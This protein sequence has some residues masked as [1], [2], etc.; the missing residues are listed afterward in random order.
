MLLL[1]LIQDPALLDAIKD[2]EPAALRKIVEE[3]YAPPQA[4]VDET[5]ASIAA[6]GADDF[7]T[8][9]KASASLAK[10]A[11]LVG[12]ILRE[13]LAATTDAEVKARLEGILRHVRSDFDVAVR[14]AAARAL[15]EARDR[16]VVQSLVNLAKTK[17]GSLRDRSKSLLKRLG[18]DP[19]TWDASKFA[20]PEKLNLGSRTNLPPGHMLVAS[21][22]KVVEYDADRKV[23]W[24][25]DTPARSARRLENGNTLIVVQLQ[26]KIVEVSPD[27]D[28]VWE[29]EH[30]RFV[31]HADV[32][33]SG[34]VVF[35]DDDH[36]IIVG[37]DKKEVVTFES[38][39]QA[40]AFQALDNDRL[41]M[42]GYLNGRV[43]E[44]DLKGDATWEIKELGRTFTA[45]RLDNGRTLVGTFGDGVKEIDGDGAVEW[46]HETAD[47]VWAAVRLGDGRTVIGT[48]RALYAVDAAGAELWRI[49]GA[50]TDVQVGE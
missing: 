22:T 21:W 19:A 8:R 25:T 48:N 40:D 2:R 10:H 44:Y 26:K 28:V 39:G 42:A 18:V 17:D 38:A 13:A 23:V 11:N 41:L 20:F 14:M 7:E 33:P 12:L 1:L 37:R 16:D 6:L 29:F 3:G 27:K 46:R 31:Y 49:D 9:E 47:D 43:V 4:L 50:V 34:D 35:S 5:R 15:L 45:R 30:H 24:E 36:L 32:L